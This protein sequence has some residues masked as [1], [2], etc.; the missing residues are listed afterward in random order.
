MSAFANLPISRKLMAAFAAVVVVI[1]ASSALVYDRLL[2][3]EWVKNWR[4]HTADVLD[5][6]QNARNAMVD[7][8]TGV[9]GYLI[10][11][12]E[13]FLESYHRGGNAYA[14]AFQ[15]IKDLTSDNPAQ[16][17]RL[18][19]LNELAKEWRSGIAEQEIALMAKPETRE[20]ARAL[21]RSMAGKTAMD[22]IRAKVDEIQGVERDLWAKRGAVQEQAFA[23]AYTMMIIGGAASIIIAT[24]MGVLLAR[25]IAGPITR[26]TSAMT[27]LAEGDTTVEVPRVNHSDEI[28]AMAASVQIFKDNMIERQ[29]AQ[30]ELAHVNR[31]TTMGQLT[32]SI[33]HE[34][35]Q[36]VAAVVTNADA[37]LRWLG[38]QPPDLEEARQALGH[39]IKDGNR[40]SD[41]IRRIR[42][43]I[44]KKVPTR[45]DRMDINETIV[46]IIALTR[47]EVL[48]NGVSLQ[49]RLAKD[50][51]L[52]QG[53]RVQLQQ[54]MLNLVINAVE[55]M[56][57]VSERLRELMIG[58]GKAASDGVVVTV[59][60]SGPGLTP[61]SLSHLFDAFYTTKPGGMGMGLS[62]CRSII[63][64]H[65]GRVWAT[66]NVPQGAIFQ[67]ILPT[68]G[69]GRSSC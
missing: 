65:G 68:S 17:S 49:T 33:A 58:S 11:G 61:E 19:E 29:R 38:A 36:P 27:T 1:F 18:D 62:I 8:E 26:M 14:A 34:V 64:D 21:E 55:A 42:T 50:L 40:A 59:R 31:V 44:N 37:A 53:D 6:L 22:L 5:T 9:R 7:Q 39:I 45:N 13:K 4:V 35:N 47:S 56:S 57:G 63:E 52:I 48:R 28:G 20:D 10:T 69:E 30:A 66:A 32:A 43:L 54:V 60:D 16:Q 67:F 3:I 46:E 12:D 25:G 15:K 23:T 2:V 24:L 41:V 51:P